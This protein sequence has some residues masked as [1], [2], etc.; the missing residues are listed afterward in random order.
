MA[1][2]STIKRVRK[3][4]EDTLAK[5]TELAWA[6]GFFDGEG[7]VSVVQKPRGTY[8][9]PLVQVGNRE[10][11]PVERFKEIVGTGFIFKRKQDG[12]NM[13]V[14]AA[15]KAEETLVQILPYLINKK[16]QA[17]LALLART[18]YSE[19]RKGVDLVSIARQIRSLN[20]K[21]GR[22]L[23]IRPL[24]EEANLI[25]SQPTYRPVRSRDN[26]T[27]RINRPRGLQS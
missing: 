19:Q 11:G 20:S 23:E 2:S 16:R 8:W 18:Y 24:S 3:N 17:E 4:A 1:T 6:A 25:G 27:E 15:R 12:F 22:R 5:A 14:A 9:Y 26:I 10:R 21:K 13:W 7:S